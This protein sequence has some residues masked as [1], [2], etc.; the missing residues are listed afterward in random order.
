MSHIVQPVTAES[1]RV[2]ATRMQLAAGRA[3]RCDCASAAGRIKRDCATAWAADAGNPAELIVM[4][5]LVLR[6]SCCRTAGR[7]EYEVVADGR[8]L[9][10]A[11]K[12]L[13]PND[14]LVY[15]DAGCTLNPHGVARL[16]EY[17]D[18]CRDSPDKMLSF[19]N[20]HTEAT[21]TKADLAVR[22]GAEKRADIMMTGQLSSGFIVLANTPSNREVIDTWTALAV[23]S[24]YRFSDDSPS[25]SPTIRFSRST[26]TTK[27]SQAWFVNCA[28]PRLPSMRCNP[29]SGPYQPRESVYRL[30]QRD[31]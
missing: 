22:L 1:R 13:G 30:G 8:A 18:I 20:P 3:I 15:L 29:M 6:S 9:K 19:M 17:F 14:L 21:W 4:R 10:E 24:D 27:A 31:S 11:L 16:R 26:G 5:S 28:E 23:E 12:E 2:R 25:G 7:D